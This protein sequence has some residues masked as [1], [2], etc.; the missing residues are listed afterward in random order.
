MASPSR[1]RITDREVVV[2]VTGSGVLM[3]GFRYKPGSKICALNL[4]VMCIMQDFFQPSSH[5]SW[6][7]V[8][9]RMLASASHLKFDPHFSRVWTFNFNT[10]LRVTANSAQSES[11]LDLT[12]VRVHIQHGPPGTPGTST[13]DHHVY[14][15][16]T[17][18]CTETATESPYRDSDCYRYL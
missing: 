8:E 9:L 14:L 18:T 17:T 10:H 16:Q 13:T 11:E 6:V 3:G 12:P 5:E 1:M 7:H 4:D 2:V 15:V